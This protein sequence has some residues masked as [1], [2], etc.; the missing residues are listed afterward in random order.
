MKK[1]VVACTLLFLVITNSVFARSG[2][3]W[4]RTNDA[5]YKNNKKSKYIV[6]ASLNKTPQGDY[7]NTSCD[8]DWAIDFDLSEFVTIQGFD[9]DYLYVDS[10]TT[11][12]A[13]LLYQ[14]L[15]RDNEKNGR[16][17]VLSPLQ[18]SNWNNRKVS[19]CVGSK[20]THT[21]GGVG[22]AKENIERDLKNLILWYKTP[23][24]N[25]PAK[26][27]EIPKGVWNFSGNLAWYPSATSCQNADIWRRYDNQQIVA[28]ANTQSVDGYNVCSANNV[29]PECVESSPSSCGSQ[30]VSTVHFSTGV[31]TTITPQPDQGYVEPKPN[32]KHAVDLN[33]AKYSLAGQDDWQDRGAVFTVD[34]GTNQ[35]NGFHVV[36]IQ[37]YLQR[38]SKNSRKNKRKVYIFTIS[39]FPIFP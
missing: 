5:V 29:L 33:F 13:N 37:K 22:P 1:V 34:Q 26:E 38:K 2:D 39:T 9:V 15:D 11:E 25:G 14:M 12:S 18:W 35:K 24:K 27:S 20:I 7:E 17:R 32:H 8:D 36:M 21:L 4:V 23:S 6:Y 28:N 31:D 16:G 30:G 10:T 3:P 19:F